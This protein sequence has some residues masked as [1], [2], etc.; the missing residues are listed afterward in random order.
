M[1][2]FWDKLK[3]EK[4]EAEAAKKDDKKGAAKKVAK[5][6]GKTKK[7]VAMVKEKSGLFS[8]I[9][10]N[11]V[12]S[13][14]AMNQQV[15]NKYVFEVSKRSNKTEIAKAI[16]ARYGVTVEQVNVV[17][18]KPKARNFRANAGMMKGRKKAIVTVKQGDKIELFKEA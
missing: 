6:A 7:D 13:E 5:K 17:L 8:G 11:P 16:E 2:A 10:M 4:Q 14:N 3:G 9:L 12:I 1:T 18:M 15:M